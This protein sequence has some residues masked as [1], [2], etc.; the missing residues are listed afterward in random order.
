MI[1][2]AKKAPFFYTISVLQIGGNKMKNRFEFDKKYN[3]VI[4]KQDY[5]FV[6]NDYEPKSYGD[7][8]F[9]N[10]DELT[11]LINKIHNDLIKANAKL[12]AAGLEEV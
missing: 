12:R 2:G 9:P 7:G 10:M 5:V 8:M 6:Y 4:D 1:I 3:R 11:D